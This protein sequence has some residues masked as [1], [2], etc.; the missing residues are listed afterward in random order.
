MTASIGLS[1]DQ[2]LFIQEAFAASWAVTAADELGV[3]ERLD[4]GPV[5][6]GTLA[7]DCAIGE[8]G[9]RLLLSALAGLGLVVPEGSRRY[10]GV[11]PG[12]SRVPRVF[13]LWPRLAEAIRNDRPLIAM[14]THAGAEAIYPDFVPLLGAVLGTLV[15]RVADRLSAP[16]LKVLDVGAGAATWSLALAARDP[17]CRVTAVDLPAVITVTKRAVAAAGLGDQFDYLAGDVFAVDLGG[18]AYDL[19]VVGNLCH[20]FD[21]ATNRRLLGKLFEVLRPG[22]KL[23]ILDAVLHEEMDGPRSVV[24]YSLGLLLRTSRG[25]AHPLSAYAKW[26]RNAGYEGVRLVDL[27]GDR[28]SLIT[29]HR[30]EEQHLSGVP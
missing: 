2:F 30:P 12:L 6:P 1:P 4:A 14:D 10:R 17:A 26:L 28:I 20:L 8:R 3:L 18:A 25:Q 11:T 9:A 13:S 21:E 27:Q 24:L 7:S 15:P 22:G 29:A 19:V 16:G 5:D 23:A